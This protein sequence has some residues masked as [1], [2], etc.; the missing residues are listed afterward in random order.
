MRLKVGAWVYDN[1]E[2]MSGV[3]FLP[4][5][6]NN[7]VYKQAP[8]QKCTKEEYEALLSRMPENIDWSGLT[9]YEFDDTT[10]NAKELACMSG[11][12]SI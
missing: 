11:Q 10:N 5:E 4:A 3:A 2:W 6:E 7:M 1:F 9:N 12:C 8:N